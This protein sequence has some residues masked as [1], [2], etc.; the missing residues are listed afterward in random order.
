MVSSFI[1]SFVSTTVGSGIVLYNRGFV[2]SC[3][4]RQMRNYLEGKQGVYSTAALKHRYQHCSIDSSSTHTDVLCQ[5]LLRQLLS[6]IV[7]SCPSVSVLIFTEGLNFC[8]KSINR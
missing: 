5:Q 7:G 6:I 3:D 2:G 1:L 4:K 8:C